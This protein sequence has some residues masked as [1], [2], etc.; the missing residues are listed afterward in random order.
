M[1]P[2][3][4]FHPETH[5]MSCLWHLQPTCPGQPN[6]FLE[7]LCMSQ[8]KQLCF[9]RDLGP[10]SL[11]SVLKHQGPEGAESEHGLWR[12]PVNCIMWR[13][14][15]S[16]LLYRQNAV[17][18]WKQGWTRG[19]NT[20]HSQPVQDWEAVFTPPLTSHVVAKVLGGEMI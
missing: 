16:L 9:S 4:N 3:V 14:H 8:D 19:W 15:K 7:W 17:V 6:L 1:S 2:Q 18:V 13:K 11:T 20:P 10:G 12:T 5:Q